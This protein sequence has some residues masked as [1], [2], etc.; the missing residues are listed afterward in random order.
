MEYQILTNTGYIYA[1]LIKR[2]YVETQFL[3]KMRAYDSAT[4]T[5]APE[6][7]RATGACSR[8]EPHPKFCPPI[9]TGYSVFI[10]S[11]SI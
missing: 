1:N 6:A 7:P 11:T 8:E 3:K 4:T 5:V 2:T 10:A 9:I